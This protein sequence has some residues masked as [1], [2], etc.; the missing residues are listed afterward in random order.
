M[1]VLDAGRAPD[2]V[3]RLD[4]LNPAPPL[5]GATHPGGHDQTLP[6]RVR[7][8][9]RLGPRLKGDVR[10]GVGR[11]SIGRE[12][13]SD[14]DVAGEVLG[15]AFARRLGASTNYGLRGLARLRV[16]RPARECD[17]QDQGRNR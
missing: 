1:P 5:R 8:P 2:D 16:L 14:G 12:Q 3:A 11:G 10:A 13:G 9:S 15:R 6:R 17:R 4:L 7:V